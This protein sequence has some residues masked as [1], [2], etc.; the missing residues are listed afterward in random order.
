MLIAEA[1][2][3][4]L[5]SRARVLVSVVERIPMIDPLAALVAPAARALGARMYWARPIDRFALAGFGAVVTL[6]GSG[7]ER[8]SHVDEEWSVLHR[9]AIIED[10]SGGAPGAG[11][12]LMGGFSFDP[13]GPWSDRWRDFPPASMVL[14]RLQVAAGGG[15]CWLTTNAIIEAGGADVDIVALAGLRDAILRD[16][17]RSPRASGGGAP[18]WREVDDGPAWRDMVRAAIAAIRAGALEKVVLAREVR[19][20]ASPRFDVAESL[21]RLRDAHPGCYVFGCWRGESVF[22]GASPELLVRVAGRDVVASSLAGSVS[23]GI[24]AADD[25]ARAASLLESG[26][27][28]AEHEIVS[29]AIAAGL[30]EHCDHVTVAGRPSLLSLPHVH[31]LHT[32][33]RARLRSGTSLLS[34]VERLHPTPAVGGEPRDA[35]LRFIR[36]RE[37]LDRGWYAA[38]IGWMQH[39]R[40]ELAV[41]LRCALLARGEASLFA[42]CGIVA[43]SD[44]DAEYAESEVKLLPM[45][46]ALAAV[47]TRTGR[48]RVV[49]ATGGA[50]E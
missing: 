29:R 33:V 44:P 43:D 10:P 37:P 34:L 27:D 31:H 12:A 8:F 13:E 14:P 7:P 40:G 17:R 16:A 4:S 5:A 32:E 48:G 28:V 36:D 25:A 2:A 22:V 11:P 20:L 45:K 26:K 24:D 21:R 19:G 42:G 1:R 9:D 46:A 41:A 49:G 3:R 35:A 39:G 50:M 47:A 18:A 38:P 30:A 15:R 23:R 6:A